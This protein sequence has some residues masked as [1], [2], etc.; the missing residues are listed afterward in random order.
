MSE[1]DLDGVSWSNEL[2]LHL[3]EL[4]VTEPSPALEPLAEAFQGHVRRINGL[5]AP[6]GG[7]L[8][9]T[10]MHPWMDPVAQTRLWPHDYSP[11]YQNYD[12][13]FDCRG[14]GWSN[15]QSVHLNLPFSGDEE[16]GRLHAALRLLL[17]ILPALAASSPIVEGRPA[18]CSMRGWNSIAATPAVFRRSPGSGAG[19]GVHRRGLPAE[20]P[21]AHVPRH[22]AFGSGGSSPAR[23]AQF[24]G[25]I[26]RF[27]QGAVEI[28]VLDV[29]ECPRADL[30]IC[31]AAAAV[32]R[33]LVAERWAPLAR[34]QAATTESLQEILFSSIDDGDRAAIP[35][36]GY[37]D[38]LGF[39]QRRCTAGE[40]WRHLAESVG[41]MAACS[42]CA[43][44]WT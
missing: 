5:L 6:L 42:A 4:K 20:N 28:R 40:L 22:R 14:H 26:A 43:S 27:E 24:P 41:L 21:R 44:R 12:R 13:I 32:L 38:P 35:S 19:A 3:I 18:A 37:L 1:I 15:L 9:P 33:A 30:A 2:V 23:V 34:Q 10:A 29:Q 31:A 17:P 36:E 16:F 39:P 25:A 11:V 7:R 8:M